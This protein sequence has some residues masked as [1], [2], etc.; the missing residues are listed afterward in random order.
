MSN[1]CRGSLK[2]ERLADDTREATEYVTEES[3]LLLLTLL[4]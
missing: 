2:S 3:V 4:T 1:T